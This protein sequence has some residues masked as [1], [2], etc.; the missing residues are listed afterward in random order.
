LNTRKSTVLSAFAPLA[1][2]ALL[3]AGTAGAAAPAA[4]TG[5]DFS[6]TYD[7][8]GQDHHEGPYTGTVT[9]ERVAAQSTGAYGAY[10]FTLDVPGYGVY[11][12]HAA[13]H[14]RQM[15]IHFALPDP[16]TRDYGTGIARFER[17]RSGDWRFR[18]FY[19]EPEFKDG[20]H[21]FEDCVRRKR[22]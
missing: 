7:C 8:T 22:G 14:G 1:L 21:G 5:P 16:S 10:T 6:G 4:F 18:K 2:V 17:S 11:R 20:N 12:G 19:Y 3:H 13:S 15:A 9:L